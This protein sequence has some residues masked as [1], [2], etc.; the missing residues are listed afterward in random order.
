MDKRLQCEFSLVRYVPDLVKGEF[1]NIGVVLREAGTDSLPIVR[2][3]RDWSRVRC[4]DATVDVELLESFEAEMSERLSIAEHESSKT[5]LQ[6]LEDT[7]SNS[8]QITEMRATL[9]ESLPAEM[10]LLMRMHVETLKVPA[11]RRKPSGRAGIVASMRDAFE[12]AGV[13]QMMR[14][15]IAAAQYTQA[16]DPLKIDCGYRN[17]KVRMFHAVSLESDADAAKGLAYSAE[18]LRA[19]VARET[20]AELELNAVIEPPDKVSDA[21][22]YRFGIGVM[23]SAALRVL[24]VAELGQVAEVARQELRA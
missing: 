1:L 13:W 16:G 6:V 20:G 11:G 24:T 19:G 8:L 21:E 4:L 7:L 23:E 15:R 14:K 18:N 17:G 22:Q 5:M 12:R 10:D 2:F 3:T 9:A